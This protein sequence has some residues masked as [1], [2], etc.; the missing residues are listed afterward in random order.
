MWTTLIGKEFV[1]RLQGKLSY[2]VLTLLVAVFTALALA[3]FWMVVLSVP[4]IVPVIGS[5]VGSS[6]S[7]T[8]QSLV[9]SNRGVFLFY[10]LAVCL[11]AAVFSVA[12]AV[13]SSAI[14]SERENDTFDL[15]LIGGLRA[16]SIV[17]GKLIAAVLFVLLL[18]STALPGFAIAWMFGGVSARDVGLVL[19]MLVATLAFISAVGLLFSAL[20]RTSTLAALYTYAVVY[21]LALGSLLGYLLGASAQNESMVRPLLS[22]NP[23]VTLLTVPE[24]ITSS[25]Q[26]TLPFQYRASLD[27]ASHEWLGLPLRYPRWLNTVGLYLLGTIVLALATGLAIDPCHRWRSRVGDS[28]TRPG[29]NQ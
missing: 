5:S 11:L 6:P 8:I 25:L 19:L 9:A 26:Q 21:L 15:L 20:A 28:G 1:S 3:S 23:F 13:A 10:S 27:P 18:A 4:T 7:V 17:I 12:P 22:L 24:G 14:S 29:T 2:V 16:R